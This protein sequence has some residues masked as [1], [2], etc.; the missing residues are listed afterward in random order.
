[1]I[2]SVSSELLH[3]IIQ[4]LLTRQLSM[5][6]FFSEYLRELCTNLE[7]AH[8]FINVCI[9][10]DNV[11]DLEEITTEFGLKFLFLSPYSCILNRIEWTFLK[12]KIQY[13]DI[14]AWS[15]SNLVRINRQRT[16]NDYY[17]Q[18]FWIFQTYNKKHSLIN[19]LPYIHK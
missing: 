12:L 6:T 13:G 16:S 8:G 5:V 1:M 17:W 9:I 11:C 18:L 2:R 7:E 15:K 19:G 10:L 3:Y 14:E 4:R